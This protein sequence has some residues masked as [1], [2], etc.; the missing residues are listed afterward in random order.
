[1]SYNNLH[2]TDYADA[3]FISASFQTIGLGPRHCGVGVGLLEVYEVIHLPHLL[4]WLPSPIG[5]A[6]LPDIA[7]GRQVRNNHDLYAV[8]FI[9]GVV[10]ADRK[11]VV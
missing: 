5:N 9:I 10:L 2:I 3:L 11:S 4:T 1:M 7:V 8:V 6:D